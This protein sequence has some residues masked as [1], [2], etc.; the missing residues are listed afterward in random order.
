MS[1]EIVNEPPPP[2]RSSGKIRSSAG[3]RIHLTDP[4]TGEEQIL[5]AGDFHEN[6]RRLREAQQLSDS[7]NVKKE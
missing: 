4:A 5:I 1:I 6:E 2:P 7:T 3:C